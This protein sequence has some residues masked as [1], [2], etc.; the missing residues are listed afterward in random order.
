M[1]KIILFIIFALSTITT[2]AQNQDNNGNN[3]WEQK[4]KQFKADKIAYLSSAMNFTVEEAQKFWPIYNKY[5]AL[6]DK[7]Y[8]TRRCRYNP[9]KVN[10]IPDN[11]CIAILN[12]LRKYNSEE[13]EIQQ[14]YEDELRKSF[15]A[16]F[17]LRYYNA[18]NDFKKNV[19]NKH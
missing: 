15:S 7:L 18:E 6:F 13:L 10:E 11:E 3:S 9:C 17:I 16:K 2:F 5:D 1:K 14:K 12:D 4:K 8:M 19:L